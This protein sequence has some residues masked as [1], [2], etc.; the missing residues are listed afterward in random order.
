MTIPCARSRVMG[1]NRGSRNAASK[2]C[3][4]TSAM[5]GWR[6]D[7][8][9]MQPRRS[10]RRGSQGDE[11]R[12]G[13]AQD[14]VGGGPLRRVE[15]GPAPGRQRLLDGRAG[16]PEQ[17]R[18]RLWR[19][20]DNVRRRG[21]TP[22]SGSCR[23]D[24]VEPIGGRSRRSA[25]RRPPTSS[26]SPPVRP[27]RRDTAGHRER[28]VADDPAPV[29]CGVTGVARV[30]QPDRPVLRGSGGEQAAQGVATARVGGA[31]RVGSAVHDRAD[32]P[33]VLGDRR[34]VVEVV[35]QV[36]RDHDQRAREGG[37]HA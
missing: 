33:A 34:G 15:P 11:G 23:A 22:V 36:G 5:S 29:A 4:A 24:S 2:A 28:G 32:R 35:R 25:L 14:G 1:G 21:R 20:P 19:D 9:P 6:A 7:S 10:P 16:E 12:T 18:A 30:E 27:C 17:H 31:D 13:L 3:S 26:P 37:A 8:E